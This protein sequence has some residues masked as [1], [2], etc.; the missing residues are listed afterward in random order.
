MKSQELFAKAEKVIPGGVNSPVRAFGSV[1]GNPVYIEKGAGAYVTD[2]DGNKYLDFC[3]SWGPLILGHANPVVLEAAKA[4]MNNGLTFGACNS[5][6]VEMAEL[7]CEVIPSM[8]MVRMVNSGTEATMS[9]LRLARGYTG[10]Q[11]VLKFDGCY[12]GHADYLLVAA[13]SGLLTGGI[14]SSAG[15]S[16]K[17]AADVMVLPYNDIEAVKEVFAAKGEEIAAVIVEPIAGNMGLVEPAPGFLET[18]REV[19]EKSGSVLIFDEVITGFRLGATTFGNIAG[20]TPDLTC[21]GKIVG[22]GMPLAAF[23]GKKEIMSQLAPLGSVYQAGT[24][25]GNP[26]AL[27]AGIATVKTLVNDNPYPEMEAKAAKIENAVNSLGLPV[28]CSRK[29]GMFTIFFKEEKT[30]PKNLEDVKSCDTQ[31]FARYH[32]SML[33]KGFYLSPSQ[34]ELGFVS[35]VHSDEDIERFIA[36]LIDTLKEVC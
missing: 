6:E 18:L 34:F 20:I 2:A 32:R 11:K 31:K 7:V 13:G 26:V 14:S 23:G 21:L 36:A 29:G 8:E 9:A 33:E 12:H 16:D 28:T 15:V 5:R 3:S 25:S 30:L 27:A 17:A 10:R 1:G 22:G 4:A 35:A 24:L 19:T